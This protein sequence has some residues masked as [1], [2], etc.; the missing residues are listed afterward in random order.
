VI[1]NLEND[2]LYYIT[3]TAYTA[4]GMQS[5]YSREVRARPAETE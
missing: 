2:R 4:D 1:R 5:A 3:I